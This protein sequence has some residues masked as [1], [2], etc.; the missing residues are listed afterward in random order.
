M[1][2]KAAHRAIAEAVKNNEPVSDLEFIGVS[3]RTI[4]VLDA[5]GI[6]T[7][8]KLMYK[9]PKQLYGIK[10]LGAKSINQLLKALE[11]YH[12]LP[13]MRDGHIGKL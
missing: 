5:N 9:T 12:L 13:E 6:D 7:M 2:P 3:E 1:F 8:K 11:L 10:S 4:S